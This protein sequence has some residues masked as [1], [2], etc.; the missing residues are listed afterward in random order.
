MKISIIGAGNVGSALA[1]RVLAHNLADLVLL[2]IVEDL[3]KAKALDLLD[4]SPIMGYKKHIHGTSDYKEISGSNIVLITAGLP[5]RP[6][7]SREDL[8]SKNAAIIKTVV[9]NLKEFS[10]NAILIVVTNPL[11]IMTYLAHEGFGGDSRKILGMAGN[12]DTARFKA[13]L[14]EELRVPP[15]KIET[16]V[17][18]SHGD[19]MVPLVSKTLIDGK[20]LE[21]VLNKERIERLVERT[22]KRGGEIVG[23]LKSG[24]AYFS[25]NA[26][27]FEI[28]E[29]IIND[30]EK[31]IT[32]SCI[33]KGQYG[34]SGCAI[35]VP[36]KIGN[37]GIREILEWQL[38]SRELN[39][40]RD[41]AKAAK[42]VLNKL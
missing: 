22:K 25:P 39:A 42:V 30:T 27:C 9:K 2:D 6:G 7:M 37:G 32:C 38:P 34:I 14:W 20:P 41:S 5:R 29:A 8:I 12:L 1:E 24:S 33:L 26:A 11:D 28:L 4:A 17:V 23:L 31:T 3:A 36:A 19:T 13:L 21:S 18:G 40:L 15:E 16:F 10:P 35:G